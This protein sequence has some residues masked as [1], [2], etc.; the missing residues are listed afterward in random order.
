MKLRC[1]IWLTLLAVVCFYAKTLS[2]VQRDLLY[3]P[4]HSYVSPQKAELP[5]F[6]ENVLT[7]SDGT[8]VMTWYAVGDKQKPALLFF[9]G[10]AFQIA[11]YAPHLLPFVEK[12]YG[13][14]MM[15]YRNFGNTKGVTLQEDIFADAA[16]TFDWLTAQG[17]PQI[18]V[19]GYSYG[20]A[21]AAG[22]TTRR[23]VQKLILTAPFASMR[24]LVAEKPVPLGSWVMRDTYPSA[25]Y[26]RQ[27]HNPLLVV[28]GANDSLI[29]VHHGQMMYEAAA[30]SDKE[31]AV[32]PQTDH[33]NIFFKEKNLPTIFEWLEKHGI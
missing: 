24:G 11:K 6:A 22:L 28:H 23:P 19:Y 1:G 17:Y 5:Q 2:E 31:L 15:E 3:W 4:S 13:V 33:R 7:M 14:L 20:T 29:P 27:Y 25:E 10:N 16:A 12:G 18:V 30:S 26:L 32:L 8:E 9:H 21:V